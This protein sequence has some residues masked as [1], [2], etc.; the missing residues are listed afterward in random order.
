MCGEVSGEGYR[1]TL[2][3]N[4][5]KNGLSQ[6]DGLFFYIF[7]FYKNGLDRFASWK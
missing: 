2:K 4:L 3:M 1:K 6:C 5:G 7:I